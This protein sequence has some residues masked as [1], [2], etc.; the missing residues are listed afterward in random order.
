MGTTKRDAGGARGNGDGLAGADA[1]MFWKACASIRAGD[2]VAAIE[3]LLTLA[4]ASSPVLRVRVRAVL[5]DYGVTIR[6]D[7]P[8]DPRRVSRKSPP[9]PS[10][11]PR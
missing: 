1:T 5:A 2:T 4:W 7:L 10:P 8:P 9:R 11:R 3:P 6:D